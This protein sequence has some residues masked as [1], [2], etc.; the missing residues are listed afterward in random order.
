[1]EEVFSTPPA[2]PEHFSSP[3]ACSPKPPLANDMSIVEEGRV[4]HSLRT[5]STLDCSPKVP[6]PSPLRCSLKAASI[7]TDLSS[8]MEEGRATHSRVSTENIVP[9]P[10][11]AHKIIAELLG[12]YVIIFMGCAS[13]VI[14]G[15]NMLTTIGIAVTW[16]LSVM[17]M[18]YTLGH[19]SGGHFNPAVTIALAA[20]G[21]FPWREVLGYVAS[22]IAASILAIGT[23]I[24]L[25]HGPEKKNIS[26][27]TTTQYNT[28]TT[29]APR[30]FAWEFIISFNLMLTICGVATDNRA[31]NE[32]S[33]VAV[34][35][36]VLINYIMAGNITVASMNPARS[37]GPALLF[38]EFQSLW[39]YIVAPI[40][41]TLTACTIYSFLRPPMHERCDKESPKSV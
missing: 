30:A 29:T 23:L 14:D 22:Q 34:G 37:I 13:M 21:K 38:R 15:R 16:G 33:G 31:I 39:L 11:N 28:R 10:T 41:G 12:T 20:S 27:Y 18:I 6:F 19:V 32:L 3:P 40:L 8:I 24:L 5:C 7:A 36:V 25:F 4:C 35:A 17:V 1:M 9:S 26:Y 2:T